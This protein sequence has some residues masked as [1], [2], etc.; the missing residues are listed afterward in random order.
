MDLSFLSATALAELVRSRRIG[1]VEVLDHF[2]DRVERLDGPINAVVVR[3]FDRARDRAR[4]LDSSKNRGVPLFGIP[5]TVKE[6]FDVA[7]LPS[8]RGHLANK[9]H[10]ATVSGLAIRRLEDAG[11]VIF[12][13]TNVPVDLADWQ[14]YNP[15]YGTTSNPWNLAHTPGGSSGGSAAALAAGLS[16]LEIGSDIGGSIRVPAHY[17]GVFG[18]KPSWALVRNFGDPGTSFA[19]AT[20]IAVIGPMAR[21]AADLATTLDLLTAPDPAETGLT[22]ALPA[23]RAAALR[24]LRIAVWP[25]QPGQATD[26]ATTAALHELAAFLERAGTTVSLTARPPFDATEAFHL[27]L[28]L[29]DAAWSAHDSEELLTLKRHAKATLPPEDTSA[30]AIMA[31]SVDMPHRV[32]LGLNE[33]RHKFRRAW[34]AFFQ[35]W[36]V[37]LMPT[38]AGSALPH[39][40]DGPTWERRARIDGREIPYNDLLFWPGLPAGCHLPSTIAPLGLSPDGLPLGVQ[41]VGPI[42]GDRT[43][44]AVAGLLE[45][46]W[47]AFK[48]PPGLVGLGKATL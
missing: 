32:W 19:A 9:D 15:V 6:S 20:D 46:A 41:I 5:M 34:T 7:G 1:C 30:D 27:Y 24:D 37:L 16:A 35:D 12:G 2:I 43:T 22:I 40:Q 3:D 36:D 29:L 48:P 38:I 45:Q 14:S 25:D 18:H 42:H 11:A 4:T 39:M 23:P 28:R 17:C 13:K 26:A 44:I 10:R 33:Q 8:T 21:S 31:R 47:L